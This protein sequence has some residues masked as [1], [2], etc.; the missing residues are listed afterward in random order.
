MQN[1][2]INNS[3]VREIPLRD[4]FKNPEKTGYTVSPDGRYYA[5][6]AP[7]NERLN[8]FVQE[9]GKKDH[10]KVTSVT[11]RD[12]SHYFWG[13]ENIILYLKDKNGDENFHLFSVE[14]DGKNEKEVTPFDNVRCN[15]V[16]ELF[17]SKTDI[18]IEL[19]KRNP[20]VYDVYRLN[21]VSGE[22]TMIAENPGNV[23][24]WLNDHDGTIRIAITSD[25][26]NRSIL[27]RDS[28]KEE[29]RTIVTTDFREQLQPLFFTFDNKQV[30]ALSNLGRD[31]S[32]IIKYDIGSGKEVEL[33]YERPDVDVSNL[34]Y[35]RKRKTLT[36][37]SYHTWKL[38][39]EFLDED[40]KNLYSRLE[41]ELAG[42]ETAIVSKD[43][44]ELKFIIRTYS[45][46]SLGS[47][48]LYD[49]ASD[50]LSKLSDV[51]PWIDEN[52]MAESRP[53]RVT[54][55]DGL[56][57]QGYLTLP[58]GKEAK[59]LPA[60]INPHGG[61]WV[62]D[63]WGYNPEV[64]FLANRGYAVLQLNY[65]G[66]TGYGR[67]FW[68]ASF[69]QWGK[70]MQD[71]LTDGVNWL[72]DQG[73]ADAKRV[74]IYGGSYGGY[75]VLAGLAFTPDVYAAGVD[76]VGVS[77]LFTFLESIPAYWKPYLE[78]LYEMVGHPEKDKELLTE[79]SPV[80]HA[81]KIKSPLFIA[82]GRMDPR[83]NVNESD[84][85]VEALKKR[86]IDVPYMVKDNEGH[87]FHNEENRFDFYEAMEKFLAKYLLV[88]KG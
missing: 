71:D 65:R 46:R 73:L 41:K 10:I 53:V 27:Y 84:Q 87:G 19:N 6:L 62:R 33:L 88:K 60:I 57:I 69:K 63:T 43:D 20:E 61:P 34:S 13:N 50:I 56:V 18:L 4:F 21:V 40:T 31:K 28:E 16:D 81:D 23:G 78:T 9:I 76:Y 68:E 72:I 8:V 2:Q 39:R 5:F 82:Q 67:K 15:I 11:D 59:D 1:T 51:S 14:K 58:L 75:A 17:D 32:A 30:Y 79:T 66:S 25:G 48:Y 37:I 64:Q 52:E 54:S 45:D 80:F 12:I 22:L 70:T 74:C 35:S 49:K 85:M 36:Q 83:V 47:Y 29:F 26:V 3:I 38:E 24:G 42:Y 77:N 44:D 86:G 55:R 7:H